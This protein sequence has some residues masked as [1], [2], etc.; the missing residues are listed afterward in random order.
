V[1]FLVNIDT[2]VQP[3]HHVTTNHKHPNFA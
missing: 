3:H 1:S 2:D